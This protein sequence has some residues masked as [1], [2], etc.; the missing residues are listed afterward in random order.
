MGI[1]LE[2]L[3]QQSIAMRIE[4][5]AVRTKW[6]KDPSGSIWET[7]MQYPPHS[8][9][10]GFM[11]DVRLIPIE[12]IFPCKA[13]DYSRE[14]NRSKL[15]PFWGDLP[16]AVVQIGQSFV[17]LDGDKRYKSIRDSNDEDAASRKIVPAQI[18]KTQDLTLRSSLDGKIWDIGEVVRQALVGHQILPHETRLKVA[19]DGEVHNV[20]DWQP[21]VSFIEP[22]N[23][24]YMLA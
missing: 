1:P 23:P 6:L 15:T 3:T 20:A 16:L 5:P 24:I 9:G 12:R 22:L 10:V 17:L 8:S 18:V 14:H 7:I 13:Y 19:F 4:S 2:S 11:S 21:H